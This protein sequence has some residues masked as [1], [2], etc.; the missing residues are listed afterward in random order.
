MSLYSPCGS[1]QAVASAHEH[2][3]KLLAEP[4]LTCEPP[5][6]QVAR[7]RLQK[8][9]ERD[10]DATSISVYDL[11]HPFDANKRLLAGF[12]EIAD[13]PTSALTSSQNAPGRKQG[14]L[15]PASGVAGSD[16]TAPAA[17]ATVVRS[18][19]PGL[20]DNY[21]GRDEEAE[22]LVDLL[23]QP[24]CQALLL[25]AGGGMGKSS[26]ATH[27]GKQLLGRGAVPGGALWADMREAGSAD[28]VGA[29]LC[30]C[31][32]VQQ[33]GS[34][35]TIHLPI[36]SCE[37]MYHCQHSFFIQDSACMHRQP[38]GD[39]VQW[40]HCTQRVSLWVCIIMQA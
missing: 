33:V 27:V 25:L 10:G 1:H 37:S 3:C 20:A 28:D 11:R 38:K 35:Q 32:N 2:S 23:L 12:R 39:A 29:R 16:A 7:Q 22:K 6:L 21:T 4:V 24:G 26:L 36:V 31:L 15:T 18:Q 40:S 34:F 5:C 13:A 17:A 19:L 8:H 9:I 14:A 30:D